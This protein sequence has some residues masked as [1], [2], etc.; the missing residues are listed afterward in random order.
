MVRRVSGHSG[1]DH[2]LE[3]LHALELA[4]LQLQLLQVQRRAQLARLLREALVEECRT[5]QKT[6][7][8]AK[9]TAEDYMLSNGWQARVLL[10]PDGSI[11]SRAV[12]DADGLVLSE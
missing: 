1:L 4:R 3:A 10:K 12:T 6:H 5:L 9:G 11:S 7:G 8:Q 2:A